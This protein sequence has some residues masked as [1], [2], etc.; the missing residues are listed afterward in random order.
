MNGN[1][2]NRLRQLEGLI[3]VDAWHSRLTENNRIAD[4]F[5]YVNFEEARLGD[6]VIFRLNLR[7]A[8][9]SVIVAGD[10]PFSIDP[11]HIW[12][13]DT[14]TSGCITYKNE[15][16]RDTSISAKILAAF[17]LQKIDASVGINA[18]TT[19]SSKTSNSSEAA[20]K[21]SP[22]R[23]D[24]DR[25][26]ENRP[27]WI[28]RP[29]GLP[30]AGDPSGE[31]LNG[32]PWAEGKRRLLRF[33]DRRDDTSIGDD[34]SVKVRISCKREDLH[35]HD[36]RVE[37]SVG[38]WQ[39]IDDSSKIIVAEEYLKRKLVGTGLHAGNLRNPFSLVILGDLWS[40]PIS[41]YELHDI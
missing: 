24:F 37:D 26:I 29:S 41:R 28:M 40:A 9:I 27:T 5:M 16:E 4:L 33:V 12:R 7:R 19:Y 8:E 18:N 35:F 11:E 31:F 15:T 21:V 1:D 20:M 38:K 22:I 2:Q 34:P 6:R 32:T 13:G 39:R 3:T 30:T 36:F 23:V 14:G 25:H 10:P 17:N